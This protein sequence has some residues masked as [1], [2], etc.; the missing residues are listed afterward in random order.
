MVCLGADFQQ[1]SSEDTL[2]YIYKI[3]RI[4]LVDS[5]VDLERRTASELCCFFRVIL[6]TGISSGK[7]LK[8]LK[9]WDCRSVAT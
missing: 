8:K 4:T 7:K 3:Y 2:R 5:E 6:C 1:S 9:A